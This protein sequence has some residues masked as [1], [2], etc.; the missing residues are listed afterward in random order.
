MPRAVRC[1]TVSVTV[2]TLPATVT[3]QR[4]RMLLTVI[5]PPLAKPPAVQRGVVDQARSL[6]DSI[7]RVAV[8]AARVSLCHR[9]TIRVTVAAEPARATTPMPRTTT[10]MS[11]STRVKPRSLRVT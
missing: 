2:P 10:A 9:P 5:G 1:V 3:I 8:S 6:S 7:R 11:T 4:S